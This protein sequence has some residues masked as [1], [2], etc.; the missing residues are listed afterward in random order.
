MVK[1][2]YTHK[3]GNTKGTSMKATNTKCHKCGSKEDLIQ[4]RECGTWGRPLAVCQQCKHDDRDYRLASQAVN[5]HLA[6]II[7]GKPIS[8]I[9]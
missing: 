2:G 4:F 1:S 6:N 9:V 5:A 3:P 7:F 8:A